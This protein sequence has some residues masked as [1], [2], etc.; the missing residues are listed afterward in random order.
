MTF[1]INENTEKALELTGLALDELE[2]VVGRFS[3]HSHRAGL[4]RGKIVVKFDGTVEIRRC[5]GNKLLWKDCYEK[6][7]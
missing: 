3:N 5:F 4:L 2:S 6:D 7:I 1:Y